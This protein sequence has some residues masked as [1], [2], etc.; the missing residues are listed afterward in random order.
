MT[1]SG[2]D[3]G[4]VPA[5]PGVGRDQELLTDHAVTALRAGGH[6]RAANGDDAVD[7]LEDPAL[8]LP[9]IGVEGNRAQRQP[10]RDG[11]RRLVLVGGERAELQPVAGQQGQR[12]CGHGHHHDDGHHDRHGA[13]A[14][15]AGAG[16]T[17]AGPL[18]AYPPGASPPRAERPGAGRPVV[19]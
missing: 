12:Q 15:P 19:E 18:G 5:G 8:L 14:G 1:P 17:G 10:R 4:E 11:L 16:P 7:D 6:Q 9:R 13:A 3:G 2:L